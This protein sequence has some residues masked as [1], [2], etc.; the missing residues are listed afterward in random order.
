MRASVV[1]GG[2]GFADLCH[3]VDRAMREIRQRFRITRPGCIPQL[4]GF[5]T[6]V[7]LQ[8]GIAA[9]EAGDRGLDASVPGPSTPTEPEQVTVPVIWQPIDHADMRSRHWRDMAHHLAMRRNTF[10]GICLECRRGRDCGV[11]E[12]S[13]C[14][15]CLARE[16]PCSRSG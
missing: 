6:G 12:D 11:L 7:C 3:Q 10:R 9:F 8:C 1:S 15:E 5:M 14:G 16:A 13:C 2:N 4:G